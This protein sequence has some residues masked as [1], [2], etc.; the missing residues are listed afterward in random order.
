M[1]AEKSHR[2]CFGFFTRRER[3]GLSLRGWLAQRSANVNIEHLA[4]GWSSRH[5][6]RADKKRACVL[7]ARDRDELQALAQTAL[8]ELRSNPEQLFLRER[9]FYTASPQARPGN[10]A[11]V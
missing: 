2:K 11:F 5:G 1:S 7:I 10:L 3:W 8:T 4:R 6:Q 9:L